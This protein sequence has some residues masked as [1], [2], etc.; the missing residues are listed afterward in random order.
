MRRE[1]SQGNTPRHAAFN[2]KAFGCVTGPSAFSLSVLEVATESGQHSSV[3][4]RIPVD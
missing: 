4:I 1:N 2:A 3:L